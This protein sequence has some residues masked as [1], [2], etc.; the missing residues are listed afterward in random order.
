VARSGSADKEDLSIFDANLAGCVVFNR[1]SLSVLIRA[2]ILSIISRKKIS[3]VEFYWD[4]YSKNVGIFSSLFILQFG[5]ERAG[6]IVAKLFRLLG[7]R[8]LPVPHGDRI[9]HYHKIQLNSEVKTRDYVRDYYHS[10][11]FRNSPFYEC[12]RIDRES[13]SSMTLKDLGY[14]VQPLIENILV[15]RALGYES[16]TLA[17]ENCS[18]PAA[19]LELICERENVNVRFWRGPEVVLVA[20]TMIVVTF[21]N[22][23]SLV[24]RLF[25]PNESHPAASNDVSVMA[26]EYVDHHC[27][28]GRSTEPNYLSNHGYP[29][30]SLVAYV[31]RD[32]L[33]RVGTP[34][35]FVLAGGE[36]V[37]FLGDVKISIRE[38]LSAIALYFCLLKFVAF[39][40][41]SLA[42]TRKLLAEI[43]LHIDLNAFL[44]SYKP[45]GHFYNTIPNGNAATRYDSGI[46]TGLCRRHSVCSMTYQSRVYYREN[47]YYF[48]DSFDEHF[49]WGDAWVEAYQA[50]QFVRKFSV[51]GSEGLDSYDAEGI[52]N[53]EDILDIDKNTSKQYL[54][55]FTSDIDSFHPLHYTWDYTK[56][57]MLVLLEAVGTIRLDTGEPA[58]VILLKPKVP[59]HLKLLLGDEE[60][61]AKIVDLNLEM[62]VVAKKRHD[63]ESVVNFADKVISIGFTTPGFDALGKGKPSVYFTP[64]QGIYNSIFD[65]DDTPLVAHNLE[66]LKDFLSGKKTVDDDLL[67]SVLYRSNEPTGPRLVSTILKSLKV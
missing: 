32:Q 36:K 53:A 19:F 9:E 6:R 28:K 38:L 51:L 48:F 57:F 45:D 35:K 49:M 50:P 64:Y 11:E 59:Q 14:C 5:R 17:I 30:D 67:D 24:P 43:S 31:R 16:I 26:V 66:G 56:C 33:R 39:S 22:V 1:M 46:V 52:L 4:P 8:L 25:K 62:E 10:Q 63:T 27:A 40:R 21:L 60:I 23:L 42:L 18:L 47:V 58:Y 34:E 55:V 37:V 15:L 13:T 41:R 29:S 3:Q 2:T 65:T 20:L 12:L 54:A 7:V 44:R 61:L